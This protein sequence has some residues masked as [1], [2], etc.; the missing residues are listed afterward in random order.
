MTP[1]AAIISL[2]ALLP[3]LVWFA[4]Y[5]RQD[6]KDPEPVRLCAWAFLYGCLSA[7]PLMLIGFGIHMLKDRGAF[8]SWEFAI[9]VTIITSIV[10][11]VV[12]A[13]GE[14][15]IK[16]IATTEAIERSG[17]SFNQVIDGIIYGS[18]V[19]LGFAFIENLLYLW[20]A[21]SGSLMSPEF[22]SA[23][24]IRS[25]GATLAH[26]IYSGFF[27]FCFAKA[28]LTPDVIPARSTRPT[29]E[30]YAKIPEALT[31]HILRAHI[32]TKRPSR[33]GHS[34]RALVA[35][36]FLVATILHFLYDIFVS[37]KLFGH[38]STV[39]IVP[40]LIIGFGALWHLF[41]TP[42]NY[43]L[44]ARVQQTTLASRVRNVT[45]RM[46]VLPELYSG[47]ITKL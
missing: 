14:E 1:K 45:R 11:F 34:H 15:F 28:H 19:G 36:G 38:H 23:F 35:E 33:D 10:W 31:F 17:V 26:T 43:A 8:D 29:R 30:F 44:V 24:A 40:L 13:F 41:H 47:R 18:S 9:P 46:L 16:A 4:I 39:L 5:R 42:S 22:A 20:N 3:I 2:F 12:I 32:F 37:I 25:L 21:S 27:G 6:R 7:F